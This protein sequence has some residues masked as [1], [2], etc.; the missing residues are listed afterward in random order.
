MIA[1]LRNERSELILEP[2]KKMQ[3]G[4]EEIFR[5]CSSLVKLVESPQSPNG[6][7]YQIQLAHATV[8]DYLVSQ[9]KSDTQ[10]SWFST[11]QPEASHKLIAQASLACL[12]HFSQPGS[13]R[14]DD[15]SRFLETWSSRHTLLGTGR[16]THACR[17]RY[18]ARSMTVIHCTTRCDVLFKTA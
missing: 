8:K 5:I 10:G 7:Q 9:H 2:R 14:V 17:N 3:N 12:L 1:F 4:K 6:H 18:R 16:N 13:L 15:K 11:L